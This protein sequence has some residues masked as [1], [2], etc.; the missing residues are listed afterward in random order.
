MAGPG[1]GKVTREAPMDLQQP[2]RISRTR[3]A[4]IREY[5]EDGRRATI[6]QLV[7]ALF[8]GRT[9]ETARKK[10]NRTVNK[11]RRRKKIRVV[12]TVSFRGTGRPQHVYGRRR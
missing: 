10:A 9:P 4:D 7:R 1:R 11:E 3:R 12:G 2:T 6:G 5:F 8:T